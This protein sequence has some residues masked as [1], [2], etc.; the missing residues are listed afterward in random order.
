MYKGK[1]CQDNRQKLINTFR[2]K[3]F[4]IIRDAIRGWFK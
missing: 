3:I 1:G 2:T 4:S